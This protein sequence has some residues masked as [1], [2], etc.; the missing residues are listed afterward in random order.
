VTPGLVPIK[1]KEYEE[2]KGGESLA[3]KK[4]PKKKK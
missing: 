1:E 3:K 2:N 4:T